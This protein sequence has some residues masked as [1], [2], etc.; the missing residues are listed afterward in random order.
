[1]NKRGYFFLIDAIIAMFVLAVG[2]GIVLSFSASTPPSQQVSMI[3]ADFLTPLS[4]NIE[5]I[6]NDFC[7]NEGNLTQDGNITNQKQSLINQI[8]EF[9]Y[10]NIT[11]NQDYTINL[12]QECIKEI[13]PL[14]NFAQFN[15]ELTIN[16]NIIYSNTTKAR[17]N[18]S[19]ILPNRKI[20]YGTFNETEF[21]G[22]YIAEV[23]VW[24]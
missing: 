22:P 10:R 23:W 9:Y 11:Y 13:M 12:A 4:D 19:V 8:A 6:N 17:E 21:Y 5:D 16:E 15:F 20:V 7:G 1:M 24:Q 18:A 3:S 2:V 14:E